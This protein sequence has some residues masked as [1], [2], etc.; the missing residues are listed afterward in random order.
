MLVTAQLPRN[1]RRI[2]FP[3][4]EFA[5]PQSAALVAIH[6]GEFCARIGQD[7]SELL[8]PLVSP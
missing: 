1:T 2:E 3:D 8:R 6:A 7:E 4:R 5:P